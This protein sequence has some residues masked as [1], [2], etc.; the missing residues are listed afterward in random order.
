MV[1]IAKA[2]SDRLIAPASSRPRKRRSSNQ[3]CGSKTIFSRP[4]P[5]HIDQQQSAKHRS[6]ARQK[7]A[8]FIRTWVGTFMRT[9][10]RVGLIQLAIVC[11]GQWA[12]QGPIAVEAASH[13]GVP[14]RKAILAIAY[15]D[16]FTNMIQPFWAIP[17]LGV[18][19]L[20]FRDIMGYCLMFFAV[21][22]VLVSVA[23]VVAPFLG[24]L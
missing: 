8:A 11:G 22:A 4:L 12:V 10:T 6:S 18:A 19:K 13:L 1:C 5:P 23:F 2:I 20:E 17:L 15:G 7:L 14:M 16:E 9:P 21:Y 24:V 3:R